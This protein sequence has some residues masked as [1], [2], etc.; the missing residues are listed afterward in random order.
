MSDHNGVLGALAPMASIGARAAR[1]AFWTDTEIRRDGSGPS[2]EMSDW[3]GVQPP[4]EGAGP[5]NHRHYRIHIDGAELSAAELVDAF[6]RRPNDF[7]PTS[8]A[9]FDPA[10]GP[11]GMT[12]DDELTVRLPGPWDGPVVV[13][14]T[15]PTGLRFETLQGHMEAGWIEFRTRNEDGLLVFEIESVA[16]SGDAAFDALHHP[17]KIAKLVQTEM[18]VRVL[19]SAVDISGGRMQGRPMVETDIHEGARQ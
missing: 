9:V 10:P 15:E 5:L 12:V 6:R 19:E 3:R 13:G 7:S 18:W 4:E 1:G 2:V 16:R 8:F 17:G 14:A 11:N